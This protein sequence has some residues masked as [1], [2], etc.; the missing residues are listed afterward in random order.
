M[1]G[2]G[3]AATAWCRGK[4]VRSEKRKKRRNGGIEGPEDF[5]STPRHTYLLRRCPNSTALINPAMLSEHHTLHGRSGTPPRS[6]GKPSRGT[7][8]G[9]G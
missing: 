9:F 6:V 5:S 8:V 7:M 3:G 1:S 4:G 2:E